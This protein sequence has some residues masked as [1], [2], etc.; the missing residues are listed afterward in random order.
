M[1]ILFFSLFI[2][3]SIGAIVF[4]ILFKRYRR[5]VYLLNYKLL[6]DSKRTTRS[7]QPDFLFPEFKPNQFGISLDTEV[8]MFM[9]GHNIVEGAT[10][11]YEAWILSVLAKKART[12][13]EIGTCTGKTSYLFAKN[14]PEKG[15]VHTLTLPPDTTSEYSH[16]DGDSDIA[17]K[18]AISESQFDK[19][20]YS[21][22]DVE[23]KINQ[24]FCDSKT[25][26]ETPYKGQMDLIFIDGSHAYSYLESDTEK[27]LNML[28]PGGV[29]L[30]HD[31]RNIE[32]S[33]L[34][35]Y[36]FLNNLS[37]RIKLYNIDGTSLAVY[38]SK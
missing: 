24:I 30:W 22:T 13:F 8:S 4:F 10:S 32:E 11:D 21:G 31:Y 9:K 34:D 12:I 28:S 27:A 7:V 29:I 38:I 36:K 18:F 23:H 16:N 17:M 25:F 14:M 37:E 19:F 1:A 5:K 26:D 2:I 35:V 3:A 15:I 20:I 33:A 6:K